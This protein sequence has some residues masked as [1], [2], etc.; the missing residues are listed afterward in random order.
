VLAQGWGSF[1]NSGV[2]WEYRVE[3]EY[4]RM[5]ARNT[6]RSYLLR[7][8]ISSPLCCPL[9]D[10]SDCLATAHTNLALRSNGY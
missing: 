3:R 8:I 6:Q 1:V 2:S 5:T 7:L 9:D 4:L 10:P